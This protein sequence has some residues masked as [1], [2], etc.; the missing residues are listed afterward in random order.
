M[1]VSRV[2]GA[3]RAERTSAVRQTP[4]AS[5]TTWLYRG[6]ADTRVIRDAATFAS[7]WASRIG[8]PAPRVDFAVDQVLIAFEPAGNRTI[9][10]GTESVLVEDEELSVTVKVLTVF[11]V[12]NS[13]APYLM[14]TTPRTFGPVTFETIDIT[15]TP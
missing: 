10:R 12:P 3:I 1:R 9:L 15:P 14:V 11:G 5:G 13:G 7:L 2:S 8:T 4:L 6:G